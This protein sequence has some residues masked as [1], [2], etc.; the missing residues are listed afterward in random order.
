MKWADF[1]PEKEF[2]RS[3]VRDQCLNDGT[4]RRE[5]GYRTYLSISVEDQRRFCHGDYTRYSI[6]KSPLFETRL[7]AERW[8]PN[9]ELLSR[10]WQLSG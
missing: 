4:P 6:F 7:D 10:N 9:L 5:R 3:I 1:F 2:S 8:W